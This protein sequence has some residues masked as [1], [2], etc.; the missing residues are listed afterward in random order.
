MGCS[1]RRMHHWTRST[2]ASACSTRRLS[3]SDCLCKQA[4]TRN[5]QLG[6][7]N[8]QEAKQFQARPA[9]CSTHRRPLLKDAPQKPLTLPKP[10]DLAS[11][12]RHE[13]VLQRSTLVL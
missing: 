10:F 11:Q 3:Q 6:C 4:P 7:R 13:Q 5:G 2:D 1:T 12:P 9:P 8:A